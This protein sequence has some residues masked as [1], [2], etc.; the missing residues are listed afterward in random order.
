MYMFNFSLPILF[1]FYDC[2]LLAGSM[3]CARESLGLWA[4]APKHT[5]LCTSSTKEIYDAGLLLRDTRFWLHLQP[6]SA[7]PNPDSSASANAEG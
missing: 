7:G 5:A 4:H 2:S 1:A 3:T 6:D